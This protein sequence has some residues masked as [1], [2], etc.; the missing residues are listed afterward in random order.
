MLSCEN[1]FVPGL[2]EYRFGEVNQSV[3]LKDDFA[4]WC[5]VIGFFGHDEFPVL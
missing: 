3:V 5:T 4:V 1:F 2:G